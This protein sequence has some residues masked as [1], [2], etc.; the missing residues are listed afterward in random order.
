MIEADKDMEY[1]KNSPWGVMGAVVVLF[2]LLALLG[3]GCQETAEQAADEALTPISAPLSALEKAQGTGQEAAAAT[4]RQG[5]LLSDDITVALVLTEGQTA[6]LGIDRLGEV[7]GCN[8]RIAYLSVP[9][10]SRE[11]FWVVRDALNALFALQDPTVDD[12]HNSLWQSDLSV[13]KVQSRDGQ[14]TEVWLTGEMMSSGACD[15]PRIKAQIE[16]TIS[17]F[18][19]HYQVFLNG[20]E[21]EYRCF[22]DMS[23]LCR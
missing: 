9:K 21:S 18:R 22:G 19:P 1:G 6:P 20:S 11:D 16:A 15:D 13:D 5:A 10:V 12:L 7:F 3:V 23:G 2:A 8:D 4:R 17:Q 14:T